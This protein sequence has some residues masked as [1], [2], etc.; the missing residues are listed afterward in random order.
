MAIENRALFALSIAFTASIVAYPDLPADIPPRAGRDGAFIGAPFVAFFLPVAAAAIWWIVASLGRHGPGARERAINAGAAMALFLSAFHVIM[1]FGFIGGHP[2]PGRILGIMVGVFLIVTGNELPRVRPN[3]QWGIHARHP[4]LDEDSWRRVHRL[5]GYVRVA[6]GVAVVVAG[7]WG[8]RALTQVIVLAVC[9]E[10]AVSVGAVLVLSRQKRAVIGLFLV[11]CC[12]AAAR[13]GAQGMLPAKVQSLP[14]FIDELVP[15]LMEQGHVPGAVVAVVYEGRIVLL[16]GYGQ[17]RLDTASQVDAS[18]TV[19]RIGSVTKVFTSV[20]AL[21]LANT[22]KLDLQRDVRAYVP[23]VP[24]AYGA[25]THQLLTHTAG[26]EERAEDASATPSARLR[27]LADRLRLNP[28]RQVI[29]PGTAYSYSNSNFELAGLV[30]ERVSG[31]AY[32]QYMAERIFAPLRMTG[33]TADRPTD[34]NVAEH[35]ARGYR[36]TGGAQ[37]AV[38]S[39]FSSANPSGSISTTAADMVRFMLALLGDGSVNDGRILSPEFVRTLFAPQYTPDPRIRSRGYAFLEW[40]S[41]GRRLYH[42]DGTLGDHIGVLMM[43][44]ADRF[45]IFVASNGAPPE[46]A[47]IGNLLLEPMLTYL[48]GPATSPA[49]PPSPLPDA[50]AGAR[51]VAGTYRDFRHTRND[52]A[53]LMTLMPMIQSRVTVD[54]DGA[55]RWRGHRWVEVAPLVFRSTDPPDYSADGPDHIVFRE[56]DRGK[57]GELHAWGATYERV[58]WTEQAPFH[59]GLFACCLIAFLAYGTSRGLGE[60]RRRTTMEDGRAARRCALFVSLM[61]LGFVAGLPIFFN[62]LRTSAP[63]APPVLTLWLMLPLASVVATALLPGF[64]AMAW[65][66][67]WW[68][69]GERLRFSTIAGLSVAFMAF[70]NYWKLLALPY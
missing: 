37:E 47:S 52:M 67:R 23:D 32:E 48:V 41:R 61:N 29:R 11:C 70:L 8:T 2:W 56:D 9:V 35:L 45:G 30:V 44:P 63:L 64:A 46:G 1:L 3:L 62:S 59:L 17:S 10:L 40:S 65:R 27:P 18:R 34:A 42:H 5:G 15:K 49:P 68:T 24:L 6:M 13:A 7:L 51:R 22:G 33:T 53:R 57:I 38:T 58:A 12:G 36:W 16:R 66:E 20:A 25:T 54:G 28:P 19:F 69:R 26:L 50:L 4:R 14:A 60:L 39:R 21:Q 43:A 55:I 31:L